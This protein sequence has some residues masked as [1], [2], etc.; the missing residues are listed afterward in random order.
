MLLAITMIIVLSGIVFAAQ[1]YCYY[2]YS[3]VRQPVLTRVPAEV[4]PSHC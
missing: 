4:A 3:K 2:Q 1:L